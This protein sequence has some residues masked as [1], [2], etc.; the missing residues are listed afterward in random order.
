ERKTISS[1]TPKARQRDLVVDLLENDLHGHIESDIFGRAA[2]V[3]RNHPRTLG[4]LDQEDRIR[5]V[6]FEGWTRRAVNHAERV[7][8]SCADCRL[9]FQLITSAVSTND[10]LV[11]LNVA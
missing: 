10:L 4:Q 8:R 9:A 11:I 1:C 5:S 6:L 2:G 7:N 3:S